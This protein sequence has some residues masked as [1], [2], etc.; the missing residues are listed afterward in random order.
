[1]CKSGSVGLPQGNV[2]LAV[3]D[4]K[5]F[6]LPPGGVGGVFVKGPNV[7]NGYNNTSIDT[8]F[9]KEGW[10]DTGDLGEVDEEGYLFIRGRIKELIN[11]GGEKISAAE[12]DAALLSHPDIIDAVSFPIPD[13]LYGEAVA[14]SI[15]IRDLSQSK[16]IENSLREH[17][18]KMLTNFK[19]PKQ[20]FIYDIPLPRSATGTRMKI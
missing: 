14:A 9:T 18:L 6:P 12:I 4:G 11:R 20:I 19:V 13:D 7:F 17:L 10:F 15:V 16:K 8:C 3:M 1:M 2:Q 5:G